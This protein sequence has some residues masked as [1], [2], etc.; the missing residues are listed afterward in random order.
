MKRRFYRSAPILTAFTLSGLAASLSAQIV[1]DGDTDTDFAN[2]NNWVGNTAPT[3]DTTTD[4]A[5]F[6]GATTFQPDLS[7]G[8]RGVNGLDFQT[9][10]W[11]LSGSNILSIGGSGIFSSGTNT[12]SAEIAQSGNATYSSAT[13]G[14]LNL[15]R[16][17]GNTVTFG[18]AGNTG[19][20][21]LNGPSD[22][23][24]FSPTVAFGTVTLNKGD[25]TGGDSG[26]STNNVS[27]DAGATLRFGSLLTSRGSGGGR[28]QIF[29][30]ATVN[31]TMDLNGQGLTLDDTFNWS[32]G[33]LTGSGTVTNNGSGSAQL[34]IKGGSTFDGD[35]TDG[36]GTTAMVFQTDYQLNGTAKTYSGGTT[37]D[38]GEVILN[39]GNST[40]ALG[41]GDITLIN[42]GHIKNRNNNQVLNNNIVIGTGG[43]GI[44]T[45]W[46]NGLGTSS[47]VITLN[48]VISGSEQLTIVNDGGT[49]RLLNGSN[50]HSGG[51]VNSGYVQANSG[52]FG[53]GDITL[54]GNGTERG[55]IQNFGGYDVHSNNVIVAAGGGVLKAGWNNN[56]E[57]TGVVSGSGR[58]RIQEDS[59]RVVLSNSANTFSGNIE[60]DTGDSRINVGS[61]QSGN[62]TGT[63][64]GPGTIQYDLGSGTQVLASSSTISLT[65]ASVID[66]GNLQVDTDMSSSPLFVR[67][68]A[69]VSGIGTLGVTT[70]E[71]GGT[72]APGQSPGILNTGNLSLAAAAA[73]YSAEIS[74]TTLGT[75]YDQV[76]VTGSV[77]VTGG[78]LTL[79]LTNSYTH[80]DTFILINNDG[81]DAIT[82]TFNG[83]PQG[84][85]VTNYG[86]FDWVASYTAGDGNDFGVSAV[87]EPTTGLLA[88]ASLGLLAL[89]RRK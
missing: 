8:A 59:G 15:N 82:G 3:N 1:W 21:V 77:D 88:L 81:A 61:L 52:A 58:L 28:G 89:R 37:I 27:V 23:A 76:N 60:F 6:N 34:R 20:V 51:T 4:I 42:G 44:E 12:I 38:G 39:T 16:I 63:I 22:N 47:K 79:V 84:G 85:I 11:T 10:G 66:S 45:G 9:G 72:I 65:G 40:D 24:S 73:T 56:L 33:G 7:S 35:I 14:Q 74:G 29:G 36:T 68:G 64:S 46:G 32:M 87:P 71:A 55:G 19:E 67:N 48:G 70:I 18:S 25:G 13:G 75:E 54:D 2:G 41:S 83:V 26:S 86:G 80:G 78:T 31:G 57:F 69:T 43:G 17:T 30:T 62:Y 49:T 5:Q 53:T 50:T